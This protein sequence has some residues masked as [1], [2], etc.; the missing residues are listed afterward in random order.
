MMQQYKTP[1]DSWR[2]SGFRRC[3]G[4]AEGMDV[5]SHQLTQ[6]GVNQFVSAHQWQPDKGLGLH[7]NMKVTTAIAR[8]GMA[9]MQ[10]A[11]ILDLQQT[12]RQCLLQCVANLFGAIGQSLRFLLPCQ[13]LF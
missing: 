13:T 11:L 5:A 9:G 10:M 2:G 6:C 8:T 4:D 7:G 3:G 1:S 12:G